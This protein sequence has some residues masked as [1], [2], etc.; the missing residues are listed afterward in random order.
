MANPNRPNQMAERLSENLDRWRF[1]VGTLA[2]C[3]G[4]LILC[5]LTGCNL[6]P[7]Y[8]RP[9]VNLPAAYAG[10]T[11]TPSATNSLADLPWWQIFR[12]AELQALLREALTNNYD[13][14]TAVARVEQAR[15]QFAEARSQLFPQVNYGALA[16]AGRNVGGVNQP[17]PTGV[18]GDTFAGDFNAA[19][20]VD[21]WGR[22]RNQTA[23]ARA[24]YFATEDARRNI[25]ISVIGEVAQDY[26]Q[27]LALDRQ[28]QIARDSTNSFGQ[29][30]R[31]FNQRLHG[32]IASRLE[33]ASAEALFDN[34]NATVPELE[35]QIAAQENQLNVLLGRNP[36]PVLRTN[37]SLDNELPPEI[38]PGLPATLLERRP[39]IRQSEQQLR[40]AND[41]VG[42]ARANFFPQ[43]NLTGLFGR[44]SPELAGLT[45]GNALAW[46]AAASL[47]GPLFHGGQIR[48]Q[49]QQALATREQA[50]LQ[51]Q[52]TVLNALQ[53]VSTELVARQKYADAQGQ[54]RQAVAAFQEAFKM[55]MERYR[56]GISSYYEVLQQQQQ[57]FPAEDALVQAQLNQLL[58][59]V[60]L[61]RSLGGGWDQPTP[62]FPP[63]AQ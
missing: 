19:W 62:S 2:G 46:S 30:L 53:E 6:R 24:Q 12:D 7:A 58:A 60:Q 22:L 26:F 57:L 31:I 55:A 27:L 43:L 36:G 28:L 25:M 29:S 15:A 9:R 50:A 40:S 54:R 61:Y 59:V 13:L 5:L 14:R 23:A 51:F 37:V 20:E 8:Q 11:A 33:T 17:S 45:S 42:V 21:L 41:E 4:F 63:P 44:V 16:G 32:G 18:E 38:P 48:A 34:A 47:T 56:M 1:R 52:A 3:A 39:D 49:Y 35:E 10:E